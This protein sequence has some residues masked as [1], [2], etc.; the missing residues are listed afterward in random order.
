MSMIYLKNNVDLLN[1][2]V[3]KLIFFRNVSWFHMYF[4][5]DLLYLKQ[6]VLIYMDM[7][8]GNWF[9]F[10]RLSI[11]SR[12][13]EKI[14]LANIRYVVNSYMLL[15][16]EHINTWTKHYQL[17][18]HNMEIVHI[19]LVW[20]DAEAKAVT[21]YSVL[22]SSFSDALAC[23]CHALLCLLCFALPL[24]CFYF[25]LLCFAVLSYRQW[26]ARDNAKDN[27]EGNADAEDN[28]KDT[29]RMLKAMLKAKLKTILKQ[30]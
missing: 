8:V 5:V 28:A 26:H 20:K 4:V 29:A 15:M 27:A 23:W 6:L 14:W 18:R 24:L 10:G 2:Y 25:V 22:L 3:L 11:G 19:F 30:V 13:P 12:S 21:C 9:R 1:S 17:W 16:L 7:G